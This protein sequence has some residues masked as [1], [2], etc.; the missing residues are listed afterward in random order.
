MK[1][2]S[3]NI[4]INF[5][6]IDKIS[7]SIHRRLYF[8]LIDNKVDNFGLT[9]LGKS[10]L[11]IF[12]GT[13]S[14]KTAYGIDLVFR[15][16]INIV[17]AEPGEHFYLN[18]ECRNFISK[19][20]HDAGSDPQIRNLTKKIY[21]EKDGGFCEITINV[22]SDATKEF[23]A[24]DYFHLVDILRHE[25]TH[26]LDVRTHEIPNGVYNS[27]LRTKEYTNYTPEVNAMINEMIGCGIDYIK[28]EMAAGTDVSAN[29]YMKQLIERIKN[30]FKKSIDKLYPEQLKR[31]L[32]SVYNGLSK[33]LETLKPKQLTWK[34]KFVSNFDNKGE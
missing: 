29:G 16:L 2:A 5:A 4:P 26:A 28:Q 17:Q 33:H 21:K 34:D 20:E 22:R 24:D 27:G 15:I 6:R 1:I 13:F 25:I 14:D 18:A 11:P 7:R 10:G 31:V 12:I 32:T 19:K 30:Y 9:P 3:G 23:I 8:G